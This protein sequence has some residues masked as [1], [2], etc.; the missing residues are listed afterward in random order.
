MIEIVEGEPVR[1]AE[2]ELVPVVRVETEVQRRAFVGSSGVAGEGEGFVRLR[3]IAILVR[4]GM[5]ER[6][7]P[8]HDRT[9]QWLGGLLLAALVVPALM[10]IAERIMHRR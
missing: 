9:A 6:R 2:R 7:I 1:V 4:S 3:P 8:V 5:G 10:I